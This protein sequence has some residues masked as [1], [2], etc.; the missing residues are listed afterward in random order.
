MYARVGMRKL[1][2]GGSTDL[3]RHGACRGRRSC[4]STY[5]APMS[6]DAQDCCLPMAVAA[7]NPAIEDGEVF[8]CVRQ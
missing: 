8:A 5:A 6:L 2:T 1:A 4:I 7:L 3:R